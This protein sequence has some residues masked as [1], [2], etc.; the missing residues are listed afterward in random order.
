MACD[1]D[2]LRV[3]YGP[4]V[5]LVS[6]VL[7]LRRL[8]GVRMDVPSALSTMRRRNAGPRPLVIRP[9]SLEPGGPGRI[10]VSVSAST[11]EKIRSLSSTTGPRHRTGTTNAPCSA[12][13]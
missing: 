5:G 8:R 11:R 7:R 6:G 1:R 10:H 9:G 4:P 12:A 13:G 3:L 2:L